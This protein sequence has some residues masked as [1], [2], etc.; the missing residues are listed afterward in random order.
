[1]I[2]ILATENSFPSNQHVEKLVSLHY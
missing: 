2:G 1:M